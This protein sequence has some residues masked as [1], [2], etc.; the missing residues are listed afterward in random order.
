[1][2]PAPAPAAPGVKVST[3]Y[4]EFVPKNLPKQAQAKR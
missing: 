3:P 4:I 1:G 2:E